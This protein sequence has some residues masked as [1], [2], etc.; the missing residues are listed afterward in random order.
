MRIFDRL[1]AG[2]TTNLKLE[3]ID[4]IGMSYTSLGQKPDKEQ[5]KGM[6]QLLYND[7]IMYY[8]NMTM[9]EVAFAINQG[10]RKA[11]D[12]VSV[13]INVRTWSVW[14]NDYKKNAIQKRANRQKTDFQLHQE[15]Q[16]ALAN[17]INKA[18]QIK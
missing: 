9:E 1:K 3:C 7:L 15:N 2:D 18:K 12:G 11:E 13:F 4:L 14:L 17:T 5:M 10:L 8:K 16:K 6:A